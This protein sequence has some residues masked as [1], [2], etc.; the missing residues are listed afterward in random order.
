MKATISWVVV[1]LVG[2]I[3][4]AGYFVPLDPLQQARY[5]IIDIAITLAGVATLIGVANLLSVHGTRVRE[6]KPDWFN[7]VILIGAFAGT[8]IFGLVLSLP[9]PFFFAW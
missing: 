9:I 2:V 8:L 3:V 4:L 7:S 6:E 1:I 5:L